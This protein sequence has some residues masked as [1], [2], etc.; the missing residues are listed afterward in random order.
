MEL[1]KK[2]D[3][4]PYI[5]NVWYNIYAVNGVSVRAGN[6]GVD[7]GYSNSVSAEWPPFFE[8]WYLIIQGKVE[9][10]VEIVSHAIILIW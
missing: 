10:K 4:L 3:V 9:Q 2:I 6:V 5:V 8:Q 7:P 1:W